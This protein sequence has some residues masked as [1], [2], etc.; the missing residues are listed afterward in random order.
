LSKVAQKFHL[1]VSTIVWANN[2]SDVN[3]LA[4]GKELIILPVDGIF[5]QIAKNDTLDS[6]A[7]K[8]KVQKDNIISQNKLDARK[9]VAGESIIIPGGKIEV[10]RI[11]A[12]NRESSNR[13]GAPV[14]TASN[15]SDVSSFQGGGAINFI[16]PT[17]GKLTQG[18][19]RG[20]YAIDIGN[21][22]KGPVYAAASGK[23]IKASYGWNGGYGNVV[24][25]DHGNNVQTLYAHNEVL[26]VKE[27]DFVSQGQTIS[28]MGNTGRVYGQTGIHLHFEVIVNGVK[29]NPLS[30]FSL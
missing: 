15:I 18:Y 30:Y 29:K 19:H 22:N 28:W 5:H 12:F 16:K 1:D 27:G 2:I 21:R 10:E 13:G 26:Y 25:V 8:Y 6:I 23:I 4:V 3:Q 9:L 14:L 24:I 11:I 7:K 20:H 17:A